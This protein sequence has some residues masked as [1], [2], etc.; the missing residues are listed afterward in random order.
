MN[1]CINAFACGMLAATSI[2]FKGLEE[3]S[4]ENFS[5]IETRYNGEW[6]YPADDLASNVYVRV[7][8]LYADERSP[9]RAFIG[10]RGGGFINDGMSD[11]FVTFY[12]FVS[13]HCDEIVSNWRTYETNEMVRFTTQSAVCFSGFANQTNFANRILALYETDT[14]AVSWETIV[15]IRSPDGPKAAAHYLGLHYDTPGVSNIIMRLRTIAI[16]ARASSLS[17]A[18]NEDLSG[19]TKQN[20]LGMD[21]AGMFD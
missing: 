17:E 4:H 7:K 19:E 5:Q 18:C 9:F 2:F 12:N 20:Y 15:M 8:N 14:N 10:I 16:K 1:I 6:D 21:A 11:E 3:I 13:N